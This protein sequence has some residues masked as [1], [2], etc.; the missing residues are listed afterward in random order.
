M[1]EDEDGAGVLTNHPLDVR[2]MLGPEH[3]IEQ[4][5]V[6]QTEVQVDPTEGGQPRY[7]SFGDYDVHLVTLDPPKRREDPHPAYVAT[8]RVSRH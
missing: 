5:S 3:E 4:C 6:A 2:E 1:V 7:A 8:L